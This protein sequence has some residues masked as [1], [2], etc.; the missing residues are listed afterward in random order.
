MSRVS[1][2]EG[3]LQ[4]YEEPIMFGRGEKYL[5]FMRGSWFWASMAIYE[6]MGRRPLRKTQEASGRLGCRVMVIIYASINPLVCVRAS[7]KP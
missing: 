7:D 4:I 3:G 6:D 1:Q 5:V 2:N